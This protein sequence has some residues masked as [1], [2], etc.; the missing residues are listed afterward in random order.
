MRAESLIRIALVAA[1]VV[2]IE[3]LC[4]TGIIPRMVLI[5]PSQM[6]S[7]LVS[8]L[9]AGN[10]T[11]GILATF[12]NVAMAAVVALVLGFALGAAIHALPW[13]RASVEPILASYY[14]V[15]T[16]MFYPVFIVLFGVG[17]AAIV[18]IAVLLSVV[19][20]IAATLNGLDRIPRVMRKT[21]RVYRM[22]RLST[23]L[24][25]ELPAAAPYLFTGIKLVVAYSFIG[26]IASEFI[27]SGSGLGY[28][29]AYAYNNFENKKMYALMLLVLVAVTVINA[30]LNSVDRRLQMRRRR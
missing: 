9:I 21:A 4:R 19:A 7:E 1:F 6:A 16:F 11:G 23:I 13:L 27:L 3:A 22:S 30:L 10:L 20:M 17:D 24:R 15:P 26:V 29:I 8:I 18:A 12:G 28:E 2:A 5:P 25:I 14:A